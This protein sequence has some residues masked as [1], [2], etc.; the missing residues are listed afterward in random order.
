MVTL[1]FGWNA[2]IYYGTAGS[3]ATTEITNTRTV[4]VT[5]ESGEEDVTTRGMAVNGYRVFEPTLKGA[6]IE[7]EMIKD[8]DDAALAAFETAYHNNPSDAIALYIIPA[9][10]QSGL[11]ADFKIFNM[12]DDQPIDGVVKRT[13]TFKPCYSTRAPAWT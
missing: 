10:G 11:D 1:D 12:G 8:E 3:T 9:V 7:V 6:S 13:V 5:E 4:K 2:K